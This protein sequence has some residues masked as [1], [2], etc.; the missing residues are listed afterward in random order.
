MT[1]VPLNVPQSL[2]DPSESQA[3]SEGTVTNATRTISPCTSKFTKLVRPR[4]LEARERGLGPQVDRRR[5][6]LTHS[7]GAGRR[8]IAS[9]AC[10]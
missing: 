10:D 6:F 1:S 4:G 2:F 5:I 8:L 9:P 3:T 7:D